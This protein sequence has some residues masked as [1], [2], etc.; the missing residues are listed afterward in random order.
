MLTDLILEWY[1][2]CLLT[3]Q[4]LRFD[5]LFA[6]PGTLSIM[7][8][9]KDSIGGRITE[10]GRIRKKFLPE[11][12]KALKHG[13]VRAKEILKNAGAKRIFGT[14]YVATH[15]GGS[16]RVNDV[17]D[18]DLRTEFE[19]LYVCDCSV[20]P[21]AWGLPPTFTLIALGKR[22]AKHLIQ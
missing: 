7:I 22:L 1:A 5:R 14:W 6:H 9:E 18:S 19:N 21:E 3:A 17:L 8:K 12:I 15:P 13:Y 10:R 16:V 11:D 4:V 20:I 2:Y